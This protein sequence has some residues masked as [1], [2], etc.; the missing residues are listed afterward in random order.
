[1]FQALRFH[2]PEIQNI[3]RLEKSPMGAKMK[4]K[5][6]KDKMVMA[7]MSEKDVENMGTCVKLKLDQ[8]P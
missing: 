7:A 3:I 2:D 4:V 1:L 6:Y 8:H 5:K